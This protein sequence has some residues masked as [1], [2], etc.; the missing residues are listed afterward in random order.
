MN[1]DTLHVNRDNHWLALHQE[2][3]WLE[4]VL[5]VRDNF[6]RASEKIFSFEALLRQVETAPPIN[7][8]EFRPSRY[9]ALLEE[10]F[11]RTQDNII[12]QDFDITEGTIR[13]IQYAERI[14]LLL[15][16][17]PYLRPELLDCFRVQDDLGREIV[18]FGGIHSSASF[19]GF[20]P[21]G[22]TAMHILA[23]NDLRKR[24][25]VQ[26]VINPQHYLFRQGILSLSR[27][28]GNEP[29]LS[30]QLI[31]SDEYIDRLVRGKD[32]VPQYNESFPATILKTDKTW[33]DLFL[34]EREGE[35][36]AQARQWV[37]NYDNVRGIVGDK[38]MKGYRVLLYGPP[39]T[40]KT[41]T[42]ALLGQ[43]T[44]KPLYRIN[45]S[46]IV[47]KYVGETSKKLEMLF[48]QA[49]NKD[50]V[51]FFDEA[52]ALFGKRTSTSSAQD[53]Y[54]NQEVS[55]LLYKF[56]EYEGMIFLSTNKGV[57]L[58][59]AF[60]RRFDTQIRYSDPDEF[61]RRRLWEHLF[62][63]RQIFD[64]DP[65]IKVSELAENIQ[66]TGAWIEKFRNYC[67]L[68]TVSKGNN[69]LSAAEFRQYLSTQLSTHGG[70]VRGNIRDLF[71]SRR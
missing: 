43:A 63:N 47:D 11:S 65:A 57:D 50:W 19:R 2:L 71:R 8:I 26:A 6:F 46:N 70:S 30:S 41:L 4:G 40:G 49:A 33:D 5:S 16:M 53:R 28:M 7:P 67:V 20:L 39:G 9:A 69:S 37:K 60:S 51:L 62:I 24:A 3:N 27:T 36:V 54:A 58:D 66:V 45:I 12:L 55:Y 34:N 32:Y 17:C 42:L 10:V 44:G 21:T 23:G 15:A 35:M 29:P 48:L 61:T 22:E 59:E 18:E 13:F 52:D 25:L 14:V 64:L 31:L 68:Q 1:I 38:A 56:E